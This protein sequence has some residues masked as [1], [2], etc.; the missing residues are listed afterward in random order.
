MKN[1]LPHQASISSKLAVFALVNTLLVVSA[2]GALPTIS[3]NF[4]GGNAAGAPTQLLP[5]DVAGLIPLPNW[6]NLNGNNVHNVVLNDSNGTPT[7]VTIFFDAD[8]S[9]GSGTGTATPDRKMFNGYLGISN[10][11]N[12]RPVF[13]NNVP[14]GA[15]KL[16][17]YNVRDGQENQAYTVNADV[18][19]TLHIRHQGP[20]EYAD[21][22][23]RGSSTNP[24]ARDLCNYVQFDQ[25]QPINGTITIDCRAEAFRGIMNAGSGTGKRTS[26]ACAP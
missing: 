22:F 4:E 14:N 13:L 16:I 6:N 26:E 18:L 20:A 25:V 15:Y 7:A 23:V 1:Q 3:V 21:A 9:W 8:E 11:G 12:Y 5:T 17:M 24:N 19:N 2:L 10:D